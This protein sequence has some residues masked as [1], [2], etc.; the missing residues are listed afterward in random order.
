LGGISPEGGSWRA[1]LQFF[2][3]RPGTTISA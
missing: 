3:M 2:C 1:S